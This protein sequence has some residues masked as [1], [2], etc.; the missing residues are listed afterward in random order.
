MS[1]PKYLLKRVLLG[2]FVLIGLSIIIFVI[3][4]VVPGD[5]ARMALGSRATE[6]ALETY[7]MEM[8]LNDP[9]PKQYGYW[10][11]GVVRG[12]FGESISTKRNVLTDIKE[13]LPATLELMLYAAI[14]MVTFSIVL[15]R[16]AARFK[17][18]FWDGF[19]RVCAYIGVAIPP[20]VLAVFFVLLFGYKL[21]IIPVIGRISTG[22]VPPTTITGMY[23]IDCLLQGNISGLWNSLFHV[24]VP[25]MALC[26]GGLFQEARLV[27]NSMVE[28]MGKE[29]ITSMRGYGI[30]DSL[31]MKKYLLK[32]S[33]IPAVSVMGLDI[34][35]MMGN[36]FLV[37]TIFSWPGISRYGIN[38]MM[39]NDLNAIS[40]TVMICGILFVVINI[41]V[42]VIV[43]YLDPRIRLGGSF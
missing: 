37:E 21:D 19:I 4:R 30:P 20:F 2:I 1:L 38:A 35:A 6:A 3:A 22:F 36:A 8:H 17:D 31:I 39:S 41:V 7:R 40:G 34:A 43:A 11:Q 26:A 23:T 27:R 16:V 42:D 10:I 32:P 14:M 18:R 5:P 28:N 9:L 24:I 29:Y 33:L 15:G 12:D 25:A 13:F